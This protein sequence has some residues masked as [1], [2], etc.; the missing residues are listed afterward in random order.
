MY[1]VYLLKAEN[2]LDTTYIGSTADLVKRLKVHNSGGSIHTAKF[3][4]WI[5]HAYFSFL[6]KPKAIEF[7]QYL[8]S[9]SGRSFA[10]RNFW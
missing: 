8:K 1:Y 5:I 2:F 3:K 10:K 6:D 9:H 7:E 4:P